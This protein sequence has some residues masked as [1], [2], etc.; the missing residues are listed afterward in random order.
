MTSY[1]LEASRSASQVI[2]L[3]VPGMT[4]EA[5]A[6]LARLAEV[7]ARREQA[8]ATRKAEEEGSCLVS[9]C[10][11]VLITNR[12]GKGSSEQEGGYR[13]AKAMSQ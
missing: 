5:K 9:I 7:K 6:D 4:V 10:G 1:T 2:L 3:I 12:S 11:T 8:A 13:G